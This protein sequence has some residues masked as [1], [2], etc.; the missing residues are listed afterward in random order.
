MAA[1]ASCQSKLSHSQL[2]GDQ[3]GHRS[4]DVA[5]DLH[6]LLPCE[7]FPIDDGLGYCTNDFNHDHSMLH[8]LLWSDLAKIR[9]ILTEEW[10]ERFDF[11][12]QQRMG[13][14]TRPNQVNVSNI[15]S[16]MVTHIASVM[17]WWTVGIS[18]T[19]WIVTIVQKT[20]STVELG[21]H[22]STLNN[23]V[24]ALLTA[25]TEATKEAAV[26]HLILPSFQES[27]L[28]LSNLT[29]YISQ[30]I[31]SNYRTRYGSSQFRTPIF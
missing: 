20:N 11:S 14:Y 12:W 21:L 18:A 24:M 7:L 13:S 28:I 26:R 8:F 5:T 30:W 27:Y 10:T 23:D 3:L 2:E 25:P 31:H 15:C 16:L 4:L 29:R 17:G 6:D 1:L 22:V 19:K 9:W